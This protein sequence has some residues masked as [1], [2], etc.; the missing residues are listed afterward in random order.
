[1]SSYQTAIAVR[2][3][4]HKLR[5]KIP[6]KSNV[7]VSGEIEAR[8]MPYSLDPR[9]Y[10]PMN[11]QS[12]SIRLL[13]LLQHLFLRGFGLACDRRPVCVLP[14]GCQHCCHI[15]H[16]P[17]G[18]DRVAHE[19][20]WSTPEVTHILRGGHVVNYGCVNLRRLNLKFLPKKSEFLL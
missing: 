1:M 14:Q 18:I 3:I 19:S 5:S 6:S 8:M 12:A 11:M 15:G 17:C 20:P 7:F 2:G 10:L 4:L 16:H 9:P 13:H